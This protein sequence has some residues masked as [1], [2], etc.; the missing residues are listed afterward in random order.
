MTRKV[1]KADKLVSSATSIFGKALAKVMK[2][3]DLINAH[4]E[5]QLSLNDQDQVKIEN[6]KYS[7]EDRALKIDQSKQLIN[8]NNELAEKLKQFV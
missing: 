1:Q 6:I 2:A 8:K 4:I 7:I 3:N 5:T